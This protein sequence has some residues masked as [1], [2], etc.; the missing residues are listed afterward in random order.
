MKT[1]V[2]QSPINSARSALPS[3]RIASGLLFRS[4]ISALRTI[5]SLAYSDDG[6]AINRAFACACISSRSPWR[7][8]MRASSN[9]AADTAIELFRFGPTIASSSRRARSMFPS[10]AQLMAEITAN[11][12]RSFPGILALSAFFSADL[13]SS[14]TR[15]GE[16]AWLNSNSPKLL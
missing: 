2:L 12:S 14:R 9:R 5:A 16:P 7:K 3:A 8:A 4:V 1:A 13:R 10:L 6:S 11:S 15:S